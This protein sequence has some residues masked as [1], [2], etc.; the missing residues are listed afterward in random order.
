MDYGGSRVRPM[1]ITKFFLLSV[2]TYNE[3]NRRERVSVVDQVFGITF[4]EIQGSPYSY[5][6]YS[7]F[8]TMN[9]SVHHV[10]FT[11]ESPLPDD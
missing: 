7:L 2:C 9:S 4:L 1:V 11:C 5:T 10:S 3:Y 8:P 6:S